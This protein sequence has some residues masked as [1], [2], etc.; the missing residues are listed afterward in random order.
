MRS[1][2]DFISGMFLCFAYIATAAIVVMMIGLLAESLVRKI[3]GMSVITVN[4][5]GGMGMYIFVVF[6]IGWLYTRGEHIRATL[7]AD[8]LNAKSRR[9]LELGLHV[10][11]FAFACLAIY[12]WW[13]MFTSTLVSE[14]YYRLTGILE[15]PFHLAGTLGWVLLAIA[16]VER[17]V[18]DWKRE[19]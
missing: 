14:R 7:F 8:M 12:L 9:L 17:F 19:G 1:K 3:V 2:G 6:C 10:M 13:H 4:E 15:W 11:T 5:V 18:G 16:A